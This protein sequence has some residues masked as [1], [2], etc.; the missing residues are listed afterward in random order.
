MYHDF[1]LRI[2][3]KLTLERL[4]ASGDEF[5]NVVCSAAY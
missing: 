2:N 3:K 1:F 5:Y 4:T